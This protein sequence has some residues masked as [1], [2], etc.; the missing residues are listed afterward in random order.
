LRSKPAGAAAASAVIVLLLLTPAMGAWM[1]G[2]DLGRPSTVDLAYQWILANVPAGAGAKFAVE[3]GAL[4]LPD[5]YPTV[6]VRLLTDRGY[7]DY[8][9]E[10][11]THLL[12]ASPQFQASLRDPVTHRDAFVA[13]RTLLSRTAEVAAFEPSA[14]VPGPSLRLYQMPR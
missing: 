2:R 6:A 14:T 4:R 5:S 8:A 10:G 12:A 11:V 7:D 3:A 13:Y 9:S 1:L